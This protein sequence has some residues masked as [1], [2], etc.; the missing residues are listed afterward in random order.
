MSVMSVCVLGESW[1][2]CDFFV[3]RRIEI[4]NLARELLPFHCTEKVD[5]GHGKGYFGPFPLPAPS[6]FHFPC[7]PLP[8]RY[9]SII[10]PP[11]KTHTKNLTSRH[12]HPHLGPPSPIYGPIRPPFQRRL[13]QNPFCRHPFAPF[14]GLFASPSK[15]LTKMSTF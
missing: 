6:S 15:T 5:M 10:S 9:F 8:T 3:N 14:I 13:P 11:S 4:S 1:L 12:S 7:Q 2:G